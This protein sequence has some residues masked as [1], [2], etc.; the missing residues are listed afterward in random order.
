[1]SDCLIWEGAIDKATGYGKAYNPAT[2]KMT[3]AHRVEYER[4]VGP[5]PDGMVI[6]HLCKTRACMNVEHMEVVTQKVNARRGLGTDTHCQRGHPW[7]EWERRGCRVCAKDGWD[8]RN[9][10]ARA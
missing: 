7:V 1:M 5:I 8:R 6:D 9:E 2:K 4:W 3:T 10:E